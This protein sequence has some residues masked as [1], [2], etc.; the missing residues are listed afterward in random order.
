MGISMVIYRDMKNALQEEGSRYPH[1]IE[2]SHNRC[3]LPVERANLSDLES[4]CFEICGLDIEDISS[5][6]LRLERQLK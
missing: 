4:D 5:L 2:A 3:I 6:F 1:E